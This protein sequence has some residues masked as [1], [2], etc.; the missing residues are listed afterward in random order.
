MY[1]GGMEGC[2]GRWRSAIGKDNYFL[3]GGVLTAFS[4]CY[5]LGAFVLAVVSPPPLFFF[6]SFFASFFLLSSPCPQDCLFFT[7]VLAE[8]LG[9]CAVWHPEAAFYETLRWRKR[10]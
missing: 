9:M 2:R 1:Q 5:L 8:T 10:G 4:V 7:L 6:F 3:D